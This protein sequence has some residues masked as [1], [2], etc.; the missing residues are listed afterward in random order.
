M[1]FG[2]KWQAVPSC[3]VS[4]T[5]AF[6]M[7]RNGC[8]TY[9]V[10]VVDSAM[11]TKEIKDIPVVCNFLDMFLEDLSGLPP[12]RETE[13]TIEVIPGVAPIS[14]PL[15]RMVPIELHELKKQ[16]QEL[17]DKGHI[18]SSVAPQEHRR[19]S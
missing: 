19:Y 13:F 17:L 18:R 16:L 14:V 10:H 9:L 3:L 12:D 2:G 11:A 4:A 8:Q 6:Q 15:Y 7:I 5:I 1:I